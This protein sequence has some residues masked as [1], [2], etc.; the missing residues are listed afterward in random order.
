[1]SVDAFVDT[2]V[3]L[4]AISDAKSEAG[5]ALL[6]REV[7]QNTY[8]GWSVQVAQEF[9]V[10]ATRT[11]SGKS[12]THAVAVDWLNLWSVFPMV[13]NTSALMH[14]A[15]EVKEL[16]QLS[17]WDANIVAAAQVV[18]AGVLYSEDLSEGQDYGGVTVVNP[19]KF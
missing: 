11:G 2:N 12:L 8:W 10:N 5:K 18:G 6:A 9:Y 19:F 3:L 7:L 14:H 13:S 16:F 15:F 1:M 17:F 4:Y